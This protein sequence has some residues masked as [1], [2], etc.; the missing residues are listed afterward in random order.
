MV[1]TLTENGESVA[2]THGDTAELKDG[3]AALDEKR[4]ADFR[5][6]MS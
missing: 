1:R 3:V 4:A 5:R 6:H 2:M